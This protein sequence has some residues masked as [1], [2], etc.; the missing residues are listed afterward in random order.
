MSIFRALYSKARRATA[1]ARFG[2]LTLRL[3]GPRVFLQQL[4]N[5]I[6]GH[7]VFIVTTRQLD[8]PNFPSS[9]EC[10]VSQAS[11]EEVEELFHEM[12]HKSPNGMYELLI[13]KWYHDQGFGD[14]YITRNSDINAI[15]SVR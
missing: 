5:Q 4:K 2:L 6:Y 3:V 10:V 11:P 13:R 7:T 8:E 14:C 15:C 1:V 9:F 12:Y